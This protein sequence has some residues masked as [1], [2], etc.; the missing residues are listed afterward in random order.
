MA[1]TQFVVNGLLVGALFT[2]VAVGFALIWGVVDIINLAHGEMVMLGG[3]SSYWILNFLTG[4]AEGSVT[5]F[6][7]HH[8][9]CY[10]NC[11]CYWLCAP[12]Y[13]CRACHW[14]RHFSHAVSYIWY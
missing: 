3:Y 7:N 8:P 4:D 6:F 9:P 13:S 10:W 2:A 14:N 11:L 5:L 12:A 1:I